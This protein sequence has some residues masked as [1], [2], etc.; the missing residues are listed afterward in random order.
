MGVRESL[1][2]AGR[3]DPEAVDDEIGLERAR[4]VAGPEFC[5]RLGLVEKPLV[6]EANTLLVVNNRGF[7]HRGVLAPGPAAD[8]CG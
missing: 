4:N 6:C 5:R 2:R 7:H 1:L 8:R 3:L